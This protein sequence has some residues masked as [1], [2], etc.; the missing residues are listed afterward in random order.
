MG[1]SSSRPVIFGFGFCVWCCNYGSG[2]FNFG[3][4]FMVKI[5][6][7][8]GHRCFFDSCDSLSIYGNVELC[9]YYRG[10]RKFTPR[11]EVRV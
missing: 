8:S 9:K 3:V 5:C 1:R 11:K 2:H 6:Y 7:F 4:D 10:G